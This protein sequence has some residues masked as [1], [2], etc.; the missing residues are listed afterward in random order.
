MILKF[1]IFQGQYQDYSET[2]MKQIDDEISKHEKIWK[3]L[4]SSY[5]ALDEGT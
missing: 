5:K 3:E 1:Q 4:Q 2:D